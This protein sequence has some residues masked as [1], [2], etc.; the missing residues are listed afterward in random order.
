MNRL[1]TLEEL[2]CQEITSN[3]P[4][5]FARFMELALYHPALGYYSGGAEGTEPL[6]WGGDFFTSGD[7]H[8]L[9]GESIGRQLHQMWQLLEC[10]PRFDIVEPG[11][12]RGLLARD[13][14]RFAL[15]Q[16]P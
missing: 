4:I 13:V 8:P 1:N 9:W 14:W 3:G 16:A 5:T 6:G 10:P 7:V 15:Q 2:I 12:G 11:G